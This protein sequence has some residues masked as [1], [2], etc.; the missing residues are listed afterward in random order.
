MH[1]TRWVW[2]VRRWALVA[3]AALLALAPLL[4]TGALAQTA[5]PVPPE[6]ST[7][8]NAATGLLLAAPAMTHATPTP[9]GLVVLDPATG[10][11]VTTIDLANVVRMIPTRLPGHA[12][13]VTIDDELSVVDA[14]AGR[15]TPLSLPPGIEGGDLYAIPY[16]YSTATGRRYLL[17]G[18]GS[19]RQAV[20]VDLQTATAHDL[21]AP[22]AAAGSTIGI[23]LGAELAPDDARVLVWD[24]RDS[25]L[26]DT[27]TPERRSG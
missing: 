15:A 6:V 5:T 12:V 8:A 7:C 25:Y 16:Q 19:G 13:A 10:E 17:L 4:P 3:V 22:I 24:G 1:E 26:I 21:V 2:R 23:V 20:L 18:D 11:T 9:R 14:T 27:A